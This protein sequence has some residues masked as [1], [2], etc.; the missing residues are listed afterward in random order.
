MAAF[1]Y[2]ERCWRHDEPRRRQRGSCAP[3]FGPPGRAFPS[4]SCQ[5]AIFP[6]VPIK[7]PPEAPEL[8]APNPTPASHHPHVDAPLGPHIAQTNPPIIFSAS[9]RSPR[10][11]PHRSATTTSNRRRL[12]AMPANRLGPPLPYPSPQT[13]TVWSSLASP[14]LVPR[15]VAGIWP[16]A[17]VPLH[18]GLICFDFNI[19][20]EIFVKS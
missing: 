11:L 12:C 10:P 16:A 5:V 8:A 6:L 3:G 19:S 7:A 2:R 20:R 17:T 13:G 15:K 4:S 14:T 9:G 1:F 18:K